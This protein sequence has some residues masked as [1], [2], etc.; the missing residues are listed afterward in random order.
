MGDTLGLIETLKNAHFK[1]RQKKGIEPYDGQCLY[2][3][4]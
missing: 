3:V 4:K 2:R 1:R